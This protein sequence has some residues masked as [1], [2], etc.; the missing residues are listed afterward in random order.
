MAD[1]QLHTFDAPPFWNLFNGLLFSN[2]SFSRAL[3]VDYHESA[4]ETRPITIADR[5]LRSRIKANELFGLLLY[6]GS[7]EPV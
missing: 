7:P 1:L 6:C 2:P 3:I 5:N 4:R